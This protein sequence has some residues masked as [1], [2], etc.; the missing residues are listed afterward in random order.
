MKGKWSSG[1]IAAIIVCSICAAIVLGGTFF[2]SALQ[3]AEN[4]KHTEILQNREEQGHKSEYKNQGD[5]GEEDTEDFDSFQAESDDKKRSNAEYYDFHNEIR[6]DLSYQIEFKTYGSIIGDD[7]NISI[8]MEYPVVA[9][10]DMNGAEGINHAIQREIEEVQAYGES[11]TDWISRDQTFSFESECYVT[12]MDED[13]LS[14]VYVE[15]G[16]L[17]EEVCESYVVS[18]N[19]DMESKMAMT[20]SQLL[21]INDTF[22]VDFRERCEKQNG[23]IHFFDTLSDQDITYLL[24]AEDTLIVFFTPLGMEIGLNYSYGWVTVTYQD[25]QKYQSHL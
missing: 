20:N 22:S 7:G 2:I 1:K 8:K 12:Y 16:Y 5:K 25:Y 3:L 10:D 17:D 15:Y 13:I 14:I 18:V 19:I 6:K 4:I 23:K 9:C 11:V 24:T 21:N